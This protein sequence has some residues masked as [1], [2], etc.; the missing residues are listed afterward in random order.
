LIALASSSTDPY[1]NLALEE[2][3]LEGRLS[4]EGML[5]LYADGPCAVIGRNQNPWVEV[6]AGADLP[7]LR[8]VSGGGTVY[9]DEG[10]LNWSVIAPREAHDR[11]AELS[12]VVAAL[13][14]LGVEAAADDRGAIRIAGGGP[15]AG[16]KVSGSAR[17]LLR[18]R[19][20]HHGTLLVSADLG[21]MASCLG[22]IAAEAS[23]SPASVPARVAN[24]SSIAVGLR[25][26]DAASAL[27]LAFAG[28]PAESAEPR[29]DPK[30]AR[31]A[32]SRL[33][34]WDWTYGA[35]P[36]FSVAVGTGGGSALLEARGGIVAGVSGPG[37]IAL[38]GLVGRRF[39]YSIPEA[40]E[41]LLS[42]A[43]AAD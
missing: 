17:R 33:R 30:A 8:R 39:D 19:V 24:L 3:L 21:R 18:D 29:A 26:A 1:S 43:A 16:D 34:S 22:G 10:N 23:A 42:L 37:A 41:E 32:E 14:R 25:V 31:R 7:V 5:F 28:R 27:A 35:T 20:L 6:R 15:R 36:S 12:L 38:G 40:A 11:C 9:H 2:A 4:S 13:A